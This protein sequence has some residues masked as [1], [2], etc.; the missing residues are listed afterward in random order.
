MKKFTL[1]EEITVEN[2]LKFYDDYT[3][4]KLVSVLKS[5]PIP[6][7]NDKAV[8]VVVGK[9]FND[10]VME[11]TKDV[12]VKFYAPWCGHCKTMAP[13]YEKAAELLKESNPNIVLADFDA[14]TNEAEGVEI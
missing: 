3:N 13:E 4:G 6:E 9:S 2:V 14:T 7:K 11:E 8:K 1:T 5:D 12:L 10:I